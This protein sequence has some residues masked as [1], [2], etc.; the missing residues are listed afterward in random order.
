EVVRNELLQRE[1]DPFGIVNRLIAQ[2]TYSRGHPYWHPADGLIVDLDNLSLA[3]AA[4]WFEKRYCPANAALVI[5]G[6]VEPEDAIARA[7]RY[8][9]S[10]RPG[11]A[12]A[13][14]QPSIA[15]LAAG[16]RLTQAGATATRIYVVWN[17][18]Q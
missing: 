13:D 8:F 6:D 11:D 14:R 7:H 2:N 16:Q 10:I 18:P 15:K 5:A 4:D 1:G 3:D 17:V 12:A 9:A